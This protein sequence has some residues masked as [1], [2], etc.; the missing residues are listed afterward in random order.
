MDKFLI[1]DILLDDTYLNIFEIMPYI[2]QAYFYDEVYIINNCW[3]ALLIISLSLLCFGKK[4]QISVVKIMIMFALLF[5]CYLFYFKLMGF[6]VNLLLIVLNLSSVTI[7]NNILCVGEFS[8]LLHT[9]LSLIGLIFFLVILLSRKV[10]KNSYIIAEMIFFFLIHFYGVFYIIEMNHLL[11]I[12]VLLELLS[13]TTVVLISFKKYALS[14]VEAAWKMYIYSGVSSA[15]FI[16]GVTLIYGSIGS[17]LVDFIHV[18]NSISDIMLRDQLMVM[19]FYGLLLLLVGLFFKL[20]IVPFHTWVSDVY[21]GAPS[22]VVLNMIVISKLAYLSIFIYLFQNLLYSPGPFNVTFESIF[23][24][25]SLLTILIGA[26]CLVYQTRTKRFLAWSGI[27]MMGWI[28]LGLSLNTFEGYLS[29]I[30]LLGSYILTTFLFFMF[31]CFYYDEK[32]LMTLTNFQFIIKSQHVI[33]VCILIVTVFL[34]I[35]LPPFINFTGKFILLKNLITHQRYISLIICILSSLIV[36]APYLRFCRQLVF[37]QI[38]TL[39]QSFKYEYVLNQ[40][41]FMQGV[42]IMILAL[43]ISQ[44]TFLN[45]IVS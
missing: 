3:I 21:E 7:L 9:I 18:I 5:L 27:S 16:F 30:L 13:L 44:L 32:F 40:L 1:N 20:A 43:S 39:L 17:V 34:W 6:F 35:S 2:L 25:F 31:L 28:L 24:F 38:K 22:L 10:T 42:F 26:L 15:C 14:A 29:V 19:L 11:Y 8:N 45:L 36:T 33:L 23:I 41:T 4:K 12:Y 37:G